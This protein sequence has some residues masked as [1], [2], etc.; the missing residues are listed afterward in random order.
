[1]AMGGFVSRC[2]RKYAE[3]E[4]SDSHSLVCEMEILM[5]RIK[6]VL[7]VLFLLLT[8]I[9]ITSC[10]GLRSEFDPHKWQYQSFVD[11]P[12][13]LE[14]YFGRPGPLNRRERCGNLR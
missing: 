9:G 5:K 7:T 1:M 10:S 8:T 13:S 6:I 14:S 2:R 12:P 11:R 4:I 3:E